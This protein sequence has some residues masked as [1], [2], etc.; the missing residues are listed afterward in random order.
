MVDILVWLVCLACDG[1]FWVWVVCV[2]VYEV[3]AAFGFLGFLVGALCGWLG[4][5][6]G[7]C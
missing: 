1:W 5:F 2:V 7:C 6:C 3:G 4:G